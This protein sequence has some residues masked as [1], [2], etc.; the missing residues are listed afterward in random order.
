[1]DAGTALK[2][3]WVNDSRL[4]SVCLTSGDLLAGLFIN[5]L[6]INLLI[7]VE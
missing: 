4:M 6:I 3:S 5:Q 2:H 7:K 1:M